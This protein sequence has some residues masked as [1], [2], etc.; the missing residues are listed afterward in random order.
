VNSISPRVLEVAV[1]EIHI[2]PIGIEFIQ[3]LNVVIST[4]GVEIVVVPNINFVRSGVLIGFI[5][6]LGH[7][8]GGSH[9]K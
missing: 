7:G 1:A 3:L 8:W 2:Q 9:Q 6:N 5:A 4:I